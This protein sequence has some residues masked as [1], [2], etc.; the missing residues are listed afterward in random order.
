MEIEVKDGLGVIAVGDF[1]IGCYLKITTPVA[2]VWDDFGGSIGQYICLLPYDAT[3]KERIIGEISDALYKD[4]TEKEDELFDL[5]KPLFK[6]FQNGRYRLD[7]YDGNK[8]GDFIDG[9]VLHSPKNY[10]K[11]DDTSEIDNSSVHSEVSSYFLA[12]TTWFIEYC[13]VLLSTKPESEIDAERVKFF[14]NEIKNGKRPFAIIVSE[15]GVSGQAFILDG[16][17]KLLAY[18]NLNITPRFA[19]IR[20]IK[21]ENGPI[22]EDF[23]FL[24]TNMYPWQFEHI[25]QNWDNRDIKL[26]EKLKNPDSPLY[27]FIKNGDHEEYYKSGRIKQKAF[28]V[29]DKI[30]GLSEGWYE[31]GRKAYERYYKNNRQTGTWKSWFENGVQDSVISFNENGLWEGELVWYFSNGKMR[32]KKIIKNGKNADGQSHTI[33]REDGSKEFE[34]TYSEGALILKRK[35]NTEGKVVSLEKLNK[36]TSTYEIWNQKNAEYAEWGE[37]ARKAQ[38]EETN[39]MIRWTVAIFILVLLLLMIFGTGK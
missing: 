7:Y 28:Y 37:K 33:W 15:F 24:A 35:Y 2:V 34:Y 26:I 9:Y 12:N 10:T 23:E 8:K 30:E 16:H 17:H 4:F 27:K 36:E 25:L 29:N 18:S 20:L 3:T 39:K 5:L 32:E 19:Y 1:D 38:K 6:L 31:N 11:K 21:A 13:D 14:E 22:V